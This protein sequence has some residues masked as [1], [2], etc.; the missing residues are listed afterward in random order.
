MA[1]RFFAL[2][3]VLLLS[4]CYL[5]SDKALF[6][7]PG[8]QPFDETVVLLGIEPTGE[9]KINA[10]GAI[11]VQALVQGPSGYRTFEITKDNAKAT[12]V[13]FHALKA[14]VPSGQAYIIQ[15]QDRP[16]DTK[17]MYLLGVLHEDRLT[18]RNFEGGAALLK[19]VRARGAQIE[20]AGA[21]DPAL[22]SRKQDVEI[23]LKLLAEKPDPAKD[24]ALFAVLQ[25]TQ[26]GRTRLARALATSCLAMAGH[27]QHAEVKALR[28]PHNVGVLMAQLPHKTALPV[29]KAARRAQQDVDGMR[30]ST[31]VE[32]ALARSYFAAKDYKTAF[33]TIDRI[34]DQEPGLRYALRADAM[35]A[36]GKGLP[37][38]L[39]RVRSEGEALVAKGD[40]FAAYVLAHYMAYNTFGPDAYPRARSLAKIAIEAG[41][42][43]GHTVMG[44]LYHYGLGVPEDKARAFA[45]YKRGAQGIDV[46]AWKEAGLALY[47]GRGV[48]K[49]YDEAFAYLTQAADLG[50]ARAQYMTGFMLAR[51]QGVKKNERKALVRLRAAVAQDDNN[52]RAELGR[53]TFDGL[54]MTKN[55]K[56]GLELLREAERK[57]S[58]AAK[59]YLASRRAPQSNQTTSGQTGTGQTGNRPS[60][61]SSDSRPKLSGVPSQHRSDVDRLLA[62]KPIRLTQANIPFMGGLGSGLMERCGS[63]RNTAQRLRLAAFVQTS[64][65][66]AM[67]G[68]DYSNPNLGKSI[69]SAYQSQALFAAGSVVGQSTPCGAVSERIAKG[70][71]AALKGNEEGP[72]VRTCTPVHGA[73]S[74]QCLA[75]TGRQVIPNLHQQ[76][77]NRRLIKQIIERNPFLGLQIG[78]TCGIGN[79]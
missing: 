37:K 74:C 5:G 10:K 59:T 31:G 56:K 60:T 71:L 68:F 69:G 30:Q 12:E 55:T 64:V 28:A 77:F 54:G 46:T 61:Q 9:V 15:R 50:D 32:V 18:V 8:D 75:N 44:L 42:T 76:T 20:K 66:G 43:P 1:R 67:A 7:T 58:K 14:S 47:F 22:V 38:D 70:I 25:D 33:A 62:G 35:V 11:G 63:P 23:A 6:A 51:G 49:D 16:N 45:H 29:C 27:S 48:E 19:E 36:G 21:S 2:C 17:R 13:S 72:F 78:L 79:Y 39:A 40:A 53:M 65:T 52:A 41:V 73:R 34:A 4:G 3:A 24:I 26:E 57:G